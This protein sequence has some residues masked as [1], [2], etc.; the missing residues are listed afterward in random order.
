MEVTDGVNSGMEMG[1]T[2][3]VNGVCKATEDERNQTLLLKDG[4]KVEGRVSS[5]QQLPAPVRKG[6]S[7]GT[8]DYYLGEEK[9]ASYPV[10]SDR[11]IEKIS[12][13]WCVEKVFHDFFH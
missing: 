4:E 13:S 7:I 12:Y 8:V 10:L 11:T 3:C 6:Q 5:P 9:I 1:E 2:I